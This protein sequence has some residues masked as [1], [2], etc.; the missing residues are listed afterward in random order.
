MKKYIITQEQRDSVIA[1]LRKKP[2]EETEEAV[3]FFRNIPEH[4]EK[5]EVKAPKVTPKK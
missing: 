3:L 2:M 5:G 1:Y 4:K